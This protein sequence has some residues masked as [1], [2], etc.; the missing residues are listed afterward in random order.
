MATAMSVAGGYVYKVDGTV[1]LGIAIAAVGWCL[2][3]LMHGREADSEKDRAPRR[4]K[5]AVAAELGIG[6]AL[7]D[8]GQTADVLA[9]IFGDVRG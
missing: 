3:S 1:I 8:Y 6:T 9:Q 5:L 2:C 7:L 4:R